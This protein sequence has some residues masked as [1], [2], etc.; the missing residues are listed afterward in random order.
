MPVR[1][2][3]LSPAPLLDAVARLPQ[4]RHLPDGAR[5][6]WVASVLAHEPGQ[7]ARHLAQASGF[8]GS[9]IG[10]LLAASEGRFHPFSDARRVTR[11]KL[12]QD[13][14]EAPGPHRRRGLAIEP[15]A[16]EAYRARLTARGGRPR[17]DLL[18]RI[19]RYLQGPRDPSAPW[20]I[21]RV[22]DVVEEDGQLFLVNYNSPSAEQFEGL[23]DQPVPEHL[24][25][26]VHHYKALAERAGIR[27]DGMRLYA[28]GADEWDGVE[29]TVAFDPDLARRL[30]AVGEH[31]WTACV[32]SG[33]PAPVAVLDHVQSLDTLAWAGD[34]AASAPDALPQLKAHLTDLATDLFGQ[35]VLKNEADALRKDQVRRIQDALPLHA[36]PPTATR[37]DLGPVRAKI[38]WDYHP[39]RLAQAVRDA[40]AQAGTDAG[41]IDRLLASDN[42]SVPPVYSLDAV[43]QVLKHR[44]GIDVETDPDF[45][46]AQVSPRGPRPDTLVALLRDLE[47]RRPGAI[48]WPALIHYPGSRLG[49]ELARAPLAG[50]GRQVRDDTAARARALLEP[51]AHDLAVD[52]LARSQALAAADLPDPPAPRKPRR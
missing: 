48:D 34:Q 30:M 5:H 10:V 16:R 3:P 2:A 22:G 33:T 19:Q 40:L 13:P 21:G 42:L 20:L 51:A 8:G 15:V 43:I 18:E 25:A 39:D 47:R 11:A 52:H 35:A 29:R 50:A 4:A 44:K 12:L 38:D 28:F 32:M 49:V 45:D 46:V 6:A 31:Y 27:V 17:D 36:L 14:L 1:S 7:A 37:I 23:A 24:Q 26:K 41:E 9:D